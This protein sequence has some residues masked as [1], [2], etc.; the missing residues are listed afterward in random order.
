MD[1]ILHQLGELLLKAVPT[2]LLVVILNFYLKSVFFKPLQKVLKQRYDATGG[3][4]KLAEESTARAAQKTAEYEAAVRAARSE[5]YRAQEQVQR[6]LQEQHAAQIAAAR[7]RAEAMVKEARAGIA[8]E[9]ETAKAGLSGQAEALA[10]QIAE[11]I[12]RRSAA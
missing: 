3:A 12:L 10:G 11:S 8:A 4:R 6:E 2:F 5:A 7:Q 9:M 1:V